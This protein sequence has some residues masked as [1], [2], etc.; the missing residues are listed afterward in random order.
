[1][2]PDEPLLARTSA[3]R[4]PSFGQISALSRRAVLGSG[5]GTAFAGLLAPMGAGCAAPAASAPRLGFQRVAASRADAVIVPPGYQAT[6][7]APWGDPVGLAGAEPAWREDASNSADEQALQLGMH[8][9]GLQFFA[10]DGSSTHGLLVINHEYCD[11]GLLHPDGLAAWSAD[12][13]RKAQAAH[14]FSVIE[15]QAVGGR[16]ELVRPSRFARRVTARTPCEVGGPA[17]GHALLRTAADP[18]GLRILGTLANCGSGI[19]PWGTYLAG[20]EN[21]HS[22]FAAGERRTPDQRRW[23]LRRDSWYRWHEHDERFDATRHPNETHRFGWIV[24]LDPMDPASAPVKRTALGRAVHE[25]ATVAVT[26]DGRAVVYSGEDASFEFLYKFVSRDRIA[27]GGGRANRQLLDHGTLYAARFDADGRGE[28]L[29]LVHGRPG[30][31]AAEGFADQGEVLVKTRQACDRIGATPMDRPEWIALDQRTR[32]VFCALTNNEERGDAGKPGADAA[33]PRAKNSM[34]QII[35]W[36]EDADFDGL[37]FSWNHLL[38]AGDPANARAEARG[39]VRGDGF[40]CP[41]GLA[42]SP[43]GLVWICTDVSPRR[44]HQGEMASFGNNQLLACDPDSGEVRRFM[45]GPVNAELAGPA[46]TPDGRTMFVSVQ[47]P[48]ENPSER[49]DPAAPRRWS[50]WPDQRP[51]GRPRS[52]VVAVQRTDGGLLG[53]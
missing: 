16:W 15:V 45:S 1:M 47:H 6:V 49:S 39:D 8:H 50:N 2:E 19:T 24:E 3:A 33:N 23:D 40:A 9:D 34:G 13:V 17:A 44:L 12:K 31:T 48:G 37:R 14:G 21:F 38:L 51:N 32:W 30:L 20:E 52:A 53:T 18:A 4:A 27:P 5:L 29:P 36:R 26:R 43:N 25:G 10:L 22:Y 46:F 11:D 7:L 28:W 41:D 42:V 35:R